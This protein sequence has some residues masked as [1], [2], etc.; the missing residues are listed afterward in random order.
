MLIICGDKMFYLWR[1]EPEENKFLR[2]MTFLLNTD[3]EFGKKALSFIERMI[4]TYPKRFDC[5]QRRIENYLKKHPE[6]IEPQFAYVF[7]PSE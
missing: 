5:V 3:N 4:K 2:D 6:A 1:E 7:N